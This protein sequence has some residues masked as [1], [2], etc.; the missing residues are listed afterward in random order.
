MKI[1]F[2][3]KTFNDYDHQIDKFNRLL[4]NLPERDKVKKAFDLTAKAHKGQKRDEGIPYLIH[5][6]RLVNTLV[7]EFDEKDADILIAALLHDV[8]EDSDTTQEEISEQFGQRAGGFV[9]KLTR[10]RGEETEESKKRDKLIKHKKIMKAEDEVRFI[11][12][13][14]LLDNLRSMFYRDDRGVRYKRHIHEA[15][16]MTL[17]LAKSVNENISN[18]VRE[19]LKVISRP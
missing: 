19:L 3:K 2:N 4:R 9:E 18:K 1:P 7:E 5:P 16:T 13:V 15:E 8:V 11:K 6:V 17:E 14:D 12:A 10:P